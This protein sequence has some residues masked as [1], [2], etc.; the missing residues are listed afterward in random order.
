MEILKGQPPLRVTVAPLQVLTVV[1]SDILDLSGAGAPVDYTDGDPV[2]TGEGVAGPGS[3][4]TDV[5]AGALYLNTGTKAEP[6]WEALA[7]VA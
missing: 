1:A 4:Y 2:A 3:R 7:F 6:V 5:T